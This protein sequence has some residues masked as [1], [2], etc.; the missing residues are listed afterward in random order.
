MAERE[1]EHNPGRLGCVCGRCGLRTIGKNA[2]DNQNSQSR[3]LTGP[4]TLLVVAEVT[5]IHT[6]PPATR[7]MRAP[8][9]C[10]S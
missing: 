10:L 3:L 4:D 1:P 8:A 2:E 9:F 7:V 5:P 6:H